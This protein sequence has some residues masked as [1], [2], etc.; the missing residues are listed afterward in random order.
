MCIGEWAVKT[1]QLHDSPRMLT[2][3]Q[4]TV[5]RLHDNILWTH[6]TLDLCTSPTRSI[7]WAFEYLFDSTSVHTALTSPP[8]NTPHR[9]TL[10]TF[11]LRIYSFC[12]C[13]IV[14]CKLQNYSYRFCTVTRMHSISISFVS[15]GIFAVSLSF[16][17]VNIRN[18]RYKVWIYKHD[19]ACTHNFY[20]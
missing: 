4:I 12:N 3:A 20:F 18:M 14:L 17:N 1:W 8:L 19:K 15:T 16:E 9:L 6:V 11:T 13:W 2:S 5:Y 10:T 7:P